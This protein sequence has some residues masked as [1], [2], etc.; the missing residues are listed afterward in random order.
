MPTPLRFTRGSDS[1]KRQTTTSPVRVRI[2]ARSLSGGGKAGVGVG[3][4]FIILITLAAAWF[5]LRR[6]RAQRQQEDPEVDHAPPETSQKTDEQR[7][8]RLPGI[9]KLEMPKIPVA[10]AWSDLRR[11]LS[12]RQ[13]KDD[14]PSVPSTKAH[15]PR[16]ARIPGLGK[17]ELPEIS[18]GGTLSGPPPAVTQGAGDPPLLPELGGSEPPM[19]QQDYGWPSQPTSNTTTDLSQPTH[20]FEMDSN[21]QPYLERSRTDSVVLPIQIPPPLQ[22]GLPESPLMPAPETQV[23]IHPGPVPYMTVNTNT[24][25]APTNE[26]ELLASQHAHLEEERRRIEWEQAA[27][28]KQ[29]KALHG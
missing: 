8:A 7:F 3:V 22:E 24:S 17:S 16:R 18:P 2:N 26:E 15:Q 29:M 5:Y 27:L 10:T 12:K 13:Q 20:F 19:A 25:S 1:S 23:S 14:G 9:E 6:R 4:T 28:E 21:Q 11:G